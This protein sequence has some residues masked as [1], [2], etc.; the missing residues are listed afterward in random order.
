MGTQPS[1]L[2]SVEVGV[3]SSK[4][5]WKNDRRIQEPGQREKERGS[6]TPTH[7]TQRDRQ[8]STGD[9]GENTGAQQWLYLSAT[10]TKGISER[11]INVTN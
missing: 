7:H 1:R 5:G 6:A 3:V 2:L 8:G 9:T 4:V 11:I 10:H